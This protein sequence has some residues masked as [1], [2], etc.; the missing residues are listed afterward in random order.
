MNRTEHTPRHLASDNAAKPAA[1][2][3]KLPVIFGLLGFVLTLA[4][5]VC[6]LFTGGSQSDAVVTAPKLM[7]SFESNLLNHLNSHLGGNAPSTQKVYTLQD[8]DIVAPEPNP[9]CYGTATDPAEMAAILNAA[10]SMLNIDSTLFTTE[11]PIMAGSTIY[12]YLDETIFSVVWKQV[13]DDSV[14]TFSEVKIAH[15]SQFRRFLS[16]GKYNSGILHTTT[17]M[18]SSVNAVTA[19]SGDFYGYRRIGIVVNDGLVYRDQGHLLDTCYIDTEGNMH[20]TYAREMTDKETIQKFV[21]EHNI[22][23]SICFGPVMILEGKN[24][25][26]ANYNSGEINKA[27][28]RAA[29]CQMDKLHYVMVAAN[30]EEP[31]YRMKTVTQMADVLVDM[32][33]P[34]AY[35]LDGGQTAAI[36]INDQLINKVSYGAQREISDIIYF[37]TA[38]PDDE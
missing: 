19:A 18:A 15:A 4:I 34:T 10:K 11:T 14:L 22:R 13:V 26:P 1:Q 9:A 16:E 3:T 31:H 2:H 28:P 36:V 12:Y 35:A 24:V 25:V 29:L 20:F 5:L 33:V 30:T 27:Y 8:S 38:I 6:L 17:E 21:D 23:F 7:D 37:A 32:G